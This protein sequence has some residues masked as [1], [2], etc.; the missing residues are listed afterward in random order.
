MMDLAIKYL[1]YCYFMDYETCNTIRCPDTER[2]Y[3]LYL[4]LIKSRHGFQSFV[5]K[6]RHDELKIK[7]LSD[8][9]VINSPHI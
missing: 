6:L 7:E 3:E 4:E 5:N 2:D 8:G 1:L 9:A